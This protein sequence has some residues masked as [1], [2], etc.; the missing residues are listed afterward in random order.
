MIKSLDKLAYNISINLR[1]GKHLKN[2]SHIVTTYIGNDYSQFVKFDQNKYNRSIVYKDQHIEMVVI[3]W[4]PNQRTPLHDHPSN[5][6]LLKVLDGNLIEN[7]YEFNLVDKKC[8][9]ITSKFLSAGNLSYKE[10]NKILHNIVNKNNQS[11]TLHIYSPP[12][13][14]HTNY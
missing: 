7:I 10:H 1:N 11:I 12:N 5:G 8:D 4:N 9:Y 6:C 2:M 3:S 14:T 13:F